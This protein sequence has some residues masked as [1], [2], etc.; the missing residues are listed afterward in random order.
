MGVLYIAEVAEELFGVV[1]GGLG[2]IDSGKCTLKKVIIN[3]GT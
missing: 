3:L 2:K 1:M